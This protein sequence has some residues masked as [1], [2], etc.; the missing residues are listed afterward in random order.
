MPIRATFVTENA[1]T[2]IMG[3][4]NVPRH[5]CPVTSLP[6]SDPKSKSPW[7]MMM[8]MKG[9]I[10]AIVGPPGV[11]KTTLLKSLIRRYTKQT[12]NDIK[13]PVAV[14]SGKNRL[15][16]VECNNDLKSIIDICKIA[17]LV[18]LMV[19]GSFGFEMARSPILFDYGSVAHSLSQET[20][21]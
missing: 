21:Y 1:P 6:N 9:V 11:G 5:G 12:L 19:D 13:G 3:L 15:T 4:E 10:V 14:V 18:L 8:M 7:M 16:F 20:L 2:M 17:D